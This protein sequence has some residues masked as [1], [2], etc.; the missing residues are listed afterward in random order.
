MCH[1]D[2]RYPAWRQD[3]LSATP[4]RPQIPRW[5]P[6]L[7]GVAIDEVNAANV[8]AAEKSRAEFAKLLENLD[9][10]F[11][12]QPFGD[13]AAIAEPAMQLVAFLDRLL[14]QL[15]PLKFDRAA[16]NRALQHLCDAAL[17]GTPDYDSARQIAWA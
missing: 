17:N 3:R 10:P 1:H 7:V 5:P 2:L 13:P 16:A 9:A 12:R 4:G 15:K 6:A 8:T 11:R 14:I